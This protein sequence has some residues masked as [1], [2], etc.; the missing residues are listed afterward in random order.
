MPPQ[1]ASISKEE[2]GLLVYEK[3]SGKKNTLFEIPPPLIKDHNSFTSYM[4]LLKIVNGD[5]RLGLRIA[6]STNLAE[7]VSSD[8]ELR[9]GIAEQLDGSRK[10]FT[11][12]ID[13][14]GLHH[15]VDVFTIEVDDKQFTFLFSKGNELIYTHYD[16]SVSRRVVMNSSG[17]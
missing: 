8:K 11:Y 3:L 12:F 7:G 4:M 15:L 5:H 17:R 14:D 9:S 2:F 6:N 1:P 13:N 10:V 16:K